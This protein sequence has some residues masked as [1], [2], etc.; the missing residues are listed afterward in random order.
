MAEP[1][2]HGGSQIGSAT[3]TADRL[4]MSGETYNFETAQIG[5][6]AIATQAYASAV[7]AGLS[8]KP[9]VLACGSVAD[10]NIVLSGLD[11]TLDGVAIDGDG[12]LVALYNQTDASENG[13]WV[14]HAG[15]WTR[16]VWF[17]ADADVAAGALI[18]ISAL[19]T[20]AQAGDRFLL[21][22]TNDPVVDTDNLTL[23][24]WPPAAETSFAAP[25]VAVQEFGAEPVAGDATTA[26]RSNGA[27]VLPDLGYEGAAALNT[28]TF[29]RDAELQ[30]MPPSVGCVVESVAGVLGCAPTAQ[31]TPDMTVAVAAGTVYNAAYARKAYAGGNATIG[32][33]D[34]T[35]P[36]IDAIVIASNGSLAVRAGTPAGTPSAPTLTANDVLI[37]YVSVVANATEIGTAAIYD[38][39]RRSNPKD[40]EV[41]AAGDGAE[42]LF[43]LTGYRPLGTPGGFRGGLAQNYAVSPANA[44]EF[45]T[46][47]AWNTRG[48]VCGFD[49]TAPLNGQNVTFRF[50]A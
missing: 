8:V 38:H 16:P 4:K 47:D 46:S 9:E 44:S 26:I 50:R 20:R 27:P 29:R 33:A 32:A 17:D 41:Q 5:G 11:K 23:A 18:P 13:P 42:K 19:G 43:T 7:T 28:N 36:R 21:L 35:D 39:R 22:T 49:S 14:A 24:I 37:A 31:G 12:D 34:V 15:A 48:T 1:V 45:S 6:A 2:I 10:G 40:R 25:S 3:I 30:I